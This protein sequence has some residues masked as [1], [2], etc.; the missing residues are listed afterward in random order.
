MRLGRVSRRPPLNSDVRSLVDA[1]GA[2]FRDTR[3]DVLRFLASAEEQRSFAGRVSYEDY[4]SEFLCWWLDD[5]HPDGELFLS[6]F[7]PAEI[8]MLQGFSLELEA[9]GIALGSSVRTITQLHANEEWLKVM[10][11]ARSALANLSP[12]AT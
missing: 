1:R 9:H 11:Q 2:N 4:A 12:G 3:I 8:Q 10:A 7:A 5:F 6:A